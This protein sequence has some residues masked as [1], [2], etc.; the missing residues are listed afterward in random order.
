[1]YNKYITN[2][3][4]VPMKIRKIIPYD[5]FELDAIE[6]WLNEMADSGL[7]L[8]RFG[9]EK[10]IFEK[11]KDNSF[12]YSVHYVEEGQLIPKNFISH[13]DVYV[14]THEKDEVLP[15]RNFNE[16]KGITKF[17]GFDFI[18][19]LYTLTVLFISYFYFLLFRMPSS[20]FMYPI[21]ILYVS[22]IM[23]LFFEFQ[24]QNRRYKLSKFSHDDYLAQKPKN[25]SYVV[26]FWRCSI[27]IY[28]LIMVLQLVWTY[29]L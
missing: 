10:A 5:Y 4:V 19:V 13:G 28:L 18:I 11:T 23:S 9:S 21:F 25:V 29:T 1:M 12:K 2:E 16:I 27:C 3:R 6:T 14:F 24:K 22:L 15:R 8:V 7:K 17:T 26:K 20:V